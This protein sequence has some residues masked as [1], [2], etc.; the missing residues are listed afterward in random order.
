MVHSP[1][2]SF[3][4]VLPGPLKPNYSLGEPQVAIWPRDNL[5]RG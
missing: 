5:V 3:C 4:Q 1:G 2:Q